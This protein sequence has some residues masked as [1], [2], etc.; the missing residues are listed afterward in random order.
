MSAI[1]ALEIALW[2]IKGK[3]L[4]VPVYELLGGKTRDRI[5]TYCSGLS[6]FD[7]SDDE[8][9]KEFAVLKEKGFKDIEI[10]TVTVGR[11]KRVGPYT[12]MFGENPICIIKVVKRNK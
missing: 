1:S 11:A 8:M 6:N 10:V 12:M 3:A 7:M 2:D 5:R 4:G 9:A